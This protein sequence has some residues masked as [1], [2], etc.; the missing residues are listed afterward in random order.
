MPLLRLKAFIVDM[1]MI[2]M[3]MAYI[4]T[5]I[6]LDGK[7]E[8]LEN[9]NARWVIN[10]I[11]GFIIIILWTKFSMTIGMKAYNIK[12]VQENGEKLSFFYSF[13]RYLFWIISMVLIAPMFYIFF[14]KD[15]KAIWDIL[16]KSRVVF[17]N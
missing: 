16:S 11:Y 4:V 3:P 6:V 13:N 17:D 5:Y 9:V 8:F 1:F 7:N 2:M 15:K 10:I 14:N 12:V